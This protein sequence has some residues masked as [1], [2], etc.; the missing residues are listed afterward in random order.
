MSDDRAAR[1]R[2]ED[3]PRG[4]GLSIAWLAP[5]LALAIALGA[6]WRYYA[7]LGPTIEIVLTTAAGVQAGQTAIR[8]RDVEIGRVETVRFENG[9]DQ[10]VAVARMSADI[11]PW[12]TDAATFWVVRPVVSPTEISGLDTLLSGVY[13]GADLGEARGAPATRFEALDAPPPTPPN[14]AGRRLTLR[15]RDG[16]ALGPGAPV[17]FKGVEV[18]RVEA[19]RFSEDGEAVLFDVFVA[20]PYDARIGPETR[21]WDVSG[22]SLSLGAAGVEVGVGSLSSLIRGGVAFDRV[23]GAPPTPEGA[24]L[25]L[26]PS[27][28]AARRQA[29]DE[30]AGGAIRLDTVFSDSV[31]GLKPD[32]PVEY[33]GVEIGAVESL[34]IEPGQTLDATRIV[35]TLRIQP[36]RI[37]LEQRDAEERLAFFKSS[38]ERGLR[39]RLATGNLLTGALYVELIDAPDAPPATIDPDQKPHPRLPTVPTALGALQAQAQSTLERLAAL[40]IEKLFESAVATL[41]SITRLAQNPDL[42]EAPAQLNSALASAAAI[43]R[44][45]E[46]RDAAGELADAAAAAGGAADALAQ[47][48]EKLPDVSRRID[49]L[50]A[51]L[52]SVATAYGPGSTLNS[53]A[54]AA[55]REARQ[56]ARSVAT[57][58]QTLERKPN[59]LIL[60]R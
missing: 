33:R 57:L 32:A 48:T 44:T 15:A 31:R 17:S 9:V 50:I 36:R 28:E 46:E 56:A 49:A 55:L 51:T 5:L 10:V 23:P 34:S 52:E 13:I 16:A 39:A 1:A 26:Y 22:V 7:S 4:F 40:P 6:A 30:S 11:A 20:A 38:V 45:L 25:R 12:L 47:A 53:E 21:F 54:V 58:A 42:A 37:G 2:I 19:R 41:D 27:A 60:G 24:Q 3:R 59:S 29:L 18:G 35:A 14:A 8:H 43:L